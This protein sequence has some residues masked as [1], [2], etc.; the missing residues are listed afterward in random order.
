MADRKTASDVMTRNVVSVR[1]DATAA[2]VAALL[3]EKRISAVPVVDGEGR[4]VGMVSEGDLLRHPPADSPRAWWLRLFDA[5]Q[6]TLEEVAQSKSLP[7]SKLMTHDV[8][9][10]IEDAPLQLVATMLI[11]HRVKRV[12]VVRNGKIVGIVSRADVLGGLAD[13]KAS[14]LGGEAPG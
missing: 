2:E 6:V 14:N 8:L 11:R 3:L 9:A 7:A 10:V 5:T 4:L 1:P 13:S 12:P